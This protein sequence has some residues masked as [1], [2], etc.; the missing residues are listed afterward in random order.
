MLDKLPSQYT[1]Y[2]K[3]ILK[4]CTWG[5]DGNLEKFF[6]IYA[7]STNSVANYYIM[8]F[9]NGLYDFNAFISFNN[10]QI[11]PNSINNL[12]SRYNGIANGSIEDMLGSFDELET[13]NKYNMLTQKYK[14][15]LGT[16]GN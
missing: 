8:N 2:S 5:L 3:I 9:I 11:V 15:A 6:P 12:V 16:C 13:L 4:E 14:F 1:S 10:N 7:D